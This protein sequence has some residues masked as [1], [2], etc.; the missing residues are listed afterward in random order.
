MAISNSEQSIEI[1]SRTER[2]KDWQKHMVICLAL[3]IL[4]AGAFFL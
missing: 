4:A 3:A 2:R 1:F